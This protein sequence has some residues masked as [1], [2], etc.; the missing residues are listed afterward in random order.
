MI[1]RI[2]ETELKKIAGY[3]PVVSLNGPRQSGKTTLIKKCFPD[4]PYASLEDPDNRLLA[5]EDARRFL[6][7]Y[8]EGVILDEVQRTPQVFSYIQGIVDETPNIK[9]VLSGSQ[10]FLMAENITQSLAGRAGLLTLFPFSMEELEKKNLLP[11]SPEEIM[12]RGFYPRIYDKNI[13]PGLYYP[14]YLSTYVERDVRLIKNIGNL[15]LFSRFMKLC[16][17]R[18]GQLLNYSSLAND[19]GV[20][21]NTVRTWISILE[22][23]YIVFTLLPYYKN[24]NKRLIK[25]PKLYFYDTGLLCE[26][27]QVSSPEQLQMHFNRGGIFENLCLLE[28]KKYFASRGITPR[29]AFWQNNQGKEIDII[30]ETAGNTLAIEVKSGKTYTPRYAENLEYWQ[31][32]SGGKPEDSYVIYAGDIERKTKQAT[33]LPWNKISAMLD[34]TGQGK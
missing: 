5:E 14:N 32:L 17:G 18:A 9:F 31:K 13:P 15:S 29:L 21:V 12:F 24:F 7:N 25:S 23:S 22:A 30:L 26:L 16:A 27:L 1:P 33:L 3:F 20:S 34:K 6:Q 11:G 10:N 19:A 2:A 4:M 28:F 8:P